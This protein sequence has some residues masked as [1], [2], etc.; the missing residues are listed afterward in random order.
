MVAGCLLCQLCTKQSKTSTGGNKRT[1]EDNRTPGRIWVSDMAYLPECE[2]GNKFAMILCEQLSS[3]VCIFP[4]QDLRPQTMAAVVRQFLSLFPRPEVWITD[5][6]PEY[7]SV[8]T[9]ELNK[10]HVKHHEGVPNRSEIQGSAELAVKLTKL[11]LTKVVGLQSGGGRQQWSKLLP[12]VVQSINSTHP[13]SGGLSRMHLLFS[14]LYYSNEAILVENPVLLQS[15]C[16]RRL[17]QTRLNNMLKKSHKG[18][19]QSFRVGQYVLLKNDNLR[20]IKG[21]RQLIPPICRDIYQVISIEKGGF[22]YR[23]LNTRNRSERTIIHTEIKNIGF[24]DMLKM[25][26]DPKRFISNLGKTIRHQ[27]FKRGNNTA[28]RLLEWSSGTPVS[29]PIPKQHPP[30]KN[31]LENMKSP[32]DEEILLS[33]LDTE[34]VA[35]DNSPVGNLFSS[36]PDIPIAPERSNSR[37][38]LRQSPR[39]SIRL[40]SIKCPPELKGILR[41]GYKPYHVTIDD[42]LIL[43]AAQVKAF[44]HAVR[45]H[46]GLHSASFN[47]DHPNLDAILQYKFKNGISTLLASFDRWLPINTRHKRVSF[48]LN[49]QHRKE[50][51]VKS[52]NL[53]LE[54]LEWASFF[55]TTLR[56]LHLCSR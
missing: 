10:F 4:T 29:T 12:H 13:Y 33:Q 32:A 40:H 1:Y 27:S 14:P 44:K 53:T 21:S 28:L 48:K 38:Q 6:G 18:N 23:I 15:S 5:Y 16:Y 17:V 20:T 25:E 47:I 3:Y 37:Y 56:E 30:P 22:S 36:Q 51:M 24:D 45:L 46:K 8:F 50:I 35:Q 39:P 26:L 42:L 41:A 11:T 9:S 55:C 49:A 7:S 43:D 2:L 31:E 52:A 19:I 54:N 34:N